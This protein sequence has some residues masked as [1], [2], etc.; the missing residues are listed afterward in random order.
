MNCIDYTKW[1]FLGGKL[2]YNWLSVSLKFCLSVCL[3]FCTPLALLYMEIVYIIH[4]YFLWEKNPPLPY[5]YWID[6]FSLFSSLKSSVIA[7]TRRIKSSL[8]WMMVV[9]VFFINQW[10]S[11]YHSRKQKLLF[12]LL[13]KKIMIN[14]LFY[15]NDVQKLL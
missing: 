11:I 10:T 2:L 15:F 13:Y 6:S 8:L 14:L 3:S 12:F 7:E 9:L 1:Y 4:N 5:R